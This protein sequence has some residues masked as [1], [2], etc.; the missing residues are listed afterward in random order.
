M[1]IAIISDSHDNL[2]NIA[3]A[4]KYI[5]Q[6]NIATII[7]CGDVAN[8]ETLG[9][10]L[11][12]FE[13][14]IYLSLGNADQKNIKELKNKKLT[15]A[16]DYGCLKIRAKK[17]LFAHFLEIAKKIII[18]NNG[19]Q[20]IFYGHQ[21]YPMIKTDQDGTIWLNPGNLSGLFYQATFAIYDTKTNKPEL[22]LLSK[23]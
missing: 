1:K 9:F 20:A 2:P 21:H 15:I 6:N 19:Y 13:G 8:A 23:I 12:N 4:L 7:H 3:K 10:I 22:I 18:A 14:N 17:F 11:D 16:E 5:A